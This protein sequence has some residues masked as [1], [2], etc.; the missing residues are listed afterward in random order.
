MKSFI[1]KDKKYSIF[2][3][4]LIICLWILLSKLMDN[5]VLIPTIKSTLTNLINIVKDEYFFPTIKRTLL[6]SLT[7]FLISLSLAIILGLLSNFSKFVFN[8]IIPILKFL[9]SVPTIAIIILALIWLNPNILPIFIGFITVFPILYEAVLNG[10]LYVDSKIIDMAKVYKVSK[11][12]LI[13][14]IYIPSIFISLE[15]ILTSTLGLNLKMVIA[16]EALAQPKYSIG[17]SLQLEKLYL[18]TSGIFA[19]IIIILLIMSLFEYIL[20]VGKRFLKR[21]K[22]WK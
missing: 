13:K 9:K 10:I 1:L 20:G 19:W 5:E 6:R 21:I 3:R 22:Q 2:P 15:T 16:G 4:L 18:N 12:T 17:G 11:S 7:G 8:F 14:D